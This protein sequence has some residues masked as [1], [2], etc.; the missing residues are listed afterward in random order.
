MRYL[1][2]M[3]LLTIVLSTMASRCNTGTVR[4]SLHAR[5]AT[6]LSEQ[7]ENVLYSKP[8]F[9][10]TWDTRNPLPKDQA[11]E[12]RYPFAYLW[13]ALDSLSTSAGPDLLA[14][15][16]AVLMGAKDFRG[17]EGIGGV[18]SQRCY[19]AVLKSGSSFELQKYVHE[20]SITSTT[21]LQI[22]IWSAKLEEFGDGFPRNFGIRERPS[23][24]YATKIGQSFFIVSNDLKELETIATRLTSSNGTPRDTVG[25]SRRAEL[26]QHEMWGYR[27]YR[28]NDTNDKM[29]AGI[30][31]VP[32]TAEELIFFVDATKGTIVLQ[33]TLKDPTPEPAVAELFTS[34]KLPLP[35][36]SN[37]N[38]WE[39]A[40]PISTDEE[41]FERIFSINFLFG[42]GVYS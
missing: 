35:R 18:R 37:E 31:R 32:P 7:F 1:T 36:R 23:T 5:A 38:T 33:L 29:A 40:I 20:S 34:H 27:K 17:P 26:F 3:L 2:Q 22:W 10:S 42:F 16:D 28:L 11:S 15:A 25:F 41:S 12:L 14:N 30:E 24:L 39:A 6:S 9:V 4:E 21:G 8:E 13:L 19:V